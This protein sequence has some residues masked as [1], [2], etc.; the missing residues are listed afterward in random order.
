MSKTDTGYTG[1]PST[2]AFLETQIYKMRAYVLDMDVDNI[3]STSRNLQYNLPQSGEGL[4]YNVDA[5]K[6]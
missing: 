5:G 2:A 6:K 3:I 1:T 4:A